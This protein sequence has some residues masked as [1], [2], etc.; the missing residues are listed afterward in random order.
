MKKIFFIG[1]AATLLLSSCSATKKAFSENTIILGKQRS[2]FLKLKG[3][4]QITKIDYPSQ[5]FKIKPFDEG[6]YAECFIGSTWKLIPN[7]WTGSYTLQGTDK[8][9]EVTQ[10]IKFEVK[11][12]HI[13]QFKKIYSGQKAKNNIAGYIL[14]FQ[15]QSDSDF[16]LTQN[17]PF[18]NQYIKVSYHFKKV[19]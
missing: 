15:K 16:V 14:D 18:E 6:V 8:C 19:N 11:D 12:E 9:P 5:S 17:I 3:N 7:N 4:W 10:P 1:L 2:E 13:F